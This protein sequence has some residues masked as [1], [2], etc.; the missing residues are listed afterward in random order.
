MG[1]RKGA[2]MR[3][4]ITRLLF[5]A[6]MEVVMVLFI[7]ELAGRQ[8]AKGSPLLVYGA[9]P[10]GAFAVML[11]TLWASGLFSGLSSRR[12]T[13][14]ILLAATAAI[15]GLLVGLVFAVARWGT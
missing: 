15:I 11:G 1:E 9:I 10:I 12:I 4:V 5:V 2:K 3:L 14:V 8:V 6:A 13:A 7:A